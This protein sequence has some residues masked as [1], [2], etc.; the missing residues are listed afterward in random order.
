MEPLRLCARRANRALGGQGV[1]FEQKRRTL[2]KIE[3]YKCSLGQLSSETI[4]RRLN[5]GSLIKEA[6]IALRQVLEERDGAAR[7]T[8]AA[9]ERIDHGE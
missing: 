7:T 9:T 3:E 2:A 1:Q 6:Q 8:A 5:H 4:Q